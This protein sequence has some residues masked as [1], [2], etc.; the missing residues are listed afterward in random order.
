MEYSI[1][2]AYKY[3]KMEVSMNISSIY[4]NGLEKSKP[5]TT[6][7]NNIDASLKKEALKTLN[8]GIKLIM[9]HEKT[10]IDKATLFGWKES[11]ER[12]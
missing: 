3:F 9:I 8:R 10:G 12:Y 4:P 11:K 1:I 2:N 6:G 5:K 7:N